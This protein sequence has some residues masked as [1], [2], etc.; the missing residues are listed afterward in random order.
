MNIETAVICLAVLLISNYYFKR[1]VLYPPFIFCGMWLLDLTVYSFDLISIDPIHSNTLAVIVAGA[2]LFSVGGVSAF[3]VPRVIV[4]ARISLMGCA[5]HR[6]KSRHLQPWFKYVLFIILILIVI[7][8]LKSLVTA[9]S[10]GSTLSGGFM[11]QARSA[12]V[13]EVSEKGTVRTAMTYLGPWPTFAVILFQIDQRRRAFWLAL[14]IAFI[15]NILG[16]GRGGFLILLS[17]VTC[18]HLIQGGQERLLAAWRFARWPLLVFTTLFILLMFTSKD[19]SGRN[20]SIAVFARDSLIQYII[21]P[22][23]TFDYVLNHPLE[24][25]NLP[26]HTFKLFLTFA[27]SF[28]IISYGPPPALDSY[29]FVPFPSNVY[30]VYKFYFTDF[31]IGGAFAIMAVIGFGQTLLYRRA[32]CASRLGLYIFALTMYPLVMVIFDDWYV[33]FGTY[34]NAWI[35]GIVFFRLGSM[36]TGAVWRLFP[37]RSHDRNSATYLDSG[38]PAA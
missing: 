32:H 36:P 18:V 28:G 16:T 31:G 34:I 19:T 27:A 17:A 24:Y 21:G 15:A 2:F 5:G 10:Q 11:A 26:N 14:S 29:L 4:G 20:T 23:G 35:C 37:A 33:A 22:T 13:E 6:T 30:T 7:A 9:A 25:T 1:S 8:I 38:Y 12:A 3:A